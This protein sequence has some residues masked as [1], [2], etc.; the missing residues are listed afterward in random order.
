MNYFAAIFISLYS[1]EEAF[2]MMSLILE[3]Y[4]YHEIFENLLNM[5]ELTWILD[6]LIKKYYPDVDE[7]LVFLFMTWLIFLEL[8]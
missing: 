6:R 8:T 1:N 3:K 7:K 4:K 2:L 5:K